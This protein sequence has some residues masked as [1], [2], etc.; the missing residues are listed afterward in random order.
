M[1]LPAAA[2]AASIRAWAAGSRKNC[3]P[4]SA[5]WLCEAGGRARLRRVLGRRAFAGAAVGSP[6]GDPRARPAA[7]PRPGVPLRRERRREFGLSRLNP[8]REAK[9]IEQFLVETVAGGARDKIG[10]H[11]GRFKCPIQAV[12]GLHGL[13]A[14]GEKLANRNQA[15]FHSGNLSNVL[16]AANAVAHPLNVH[17]QVEGA[18]DLHADRL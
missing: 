9:A 1:R 16:H 7:S 13:V 2:K 14:V 4:F 15:A 3:A 5:K 18:G 17:N 6:D 12:V 11:A 8:G 10:A